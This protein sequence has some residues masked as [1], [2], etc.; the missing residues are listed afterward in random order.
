MQKRGLTTQKEIV[1]RC[2]NE[3]TLKPEIQNN[4]IGENAK[5]RLDKPLFFFYTKDS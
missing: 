5:E 3:Q 1:T 4:S 2:L